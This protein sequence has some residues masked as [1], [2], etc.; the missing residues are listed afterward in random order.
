MKY[1]IICFYLL[2]A[3]LF[4]FSWLEASQFALFEQ[5]IVQGPLPLWGFQTPGYYTSLLITLGPSTRKL[6]TT[7]KYQRL[8]KFFT[9]ANPQGVCKTHATPPSLP[10]SSPYSLLA[11]VPRYNLLCGPAW[12]FSFLW[13]YK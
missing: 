8:P 4:Q 10:H 7:S 9:L 2:N 1:N 6:G 3:T 5:L 12:Q 13:N 11:P